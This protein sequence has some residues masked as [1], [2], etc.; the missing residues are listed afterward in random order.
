MSNYG[1]SHLAQRA[2]S[3]RRIAGVAPVAFR[4]NPALVAEILAMTNPLSPY[5]NSVAPVTQKPAACRVSVTT[6]FSRRS[7]SFVV[8]LK[9]V[10]NRATYK[11]FRITYDTPQNAAFEAW[12]NANPDMILDASEFEAF[13]KAVQS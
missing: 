10:E 12:R 3:P 11:S 5:L 1:R 8:D 7:T 6:F 13:E 2:N 9:D 4:N